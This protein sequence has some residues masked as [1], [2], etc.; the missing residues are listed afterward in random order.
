MAPESKKF[1]LVK[2]SSLGDVVHTLPV[3][4]ALRTAF[5]K[6]FIAWIVE[7][8]SQDVLYKNPDLDELIVVRTKHW[9]RNWNLDS[10]REIREVYTRLKRH[11]F[12][13]VFDFQGLIK[14]GVFAYLSGAPNRLGF[15]RKDCRERLNTLFINHNAPY[16]GK[17]IHVI[18][19]NLCLL[20]MVEK[21]GGIA[22]IPKEFPLA[23]PQEA[24]EYIKEYL[25]NNPELTGKP[26]VGINP[27]VGFKTKQWDLKRFA[28][29]ADR[30]S[31]EMGFN[32]LLTWGPGEEEKINQITKAMTQRAWPAPPTSIHQSTALYRQLSLFVS[33]DT[34][35]L[36]LCA[37]L[38][39]PTVSIFGPTDPVRNGAYGDI[40]EVVCKKLPCSFCYK[41]RCPTQ[42]ECMDQVT[43]DDLFE[44]VKKSIATHTK[45]LAS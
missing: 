9:R 31:L 26:I 28:E 39:I 38:G 35:P 41:R 15:H 36:H 1:L 19:K 42:N 34:G 18:D 21:E 20:K 27:G 32:I 7:E 16:S 14:S 6:A 2:L 43:V 24:N 8:K 13:Y 29:L 37:A 3:L 11:R 4:R 17:N 12:D 30:I 40:H 5:P 45:V 23:V 44:Q 22:D 10:L 33:C 25:M